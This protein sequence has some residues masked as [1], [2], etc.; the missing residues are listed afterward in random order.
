MVWPWRKYF[1]KK[2][3]EEEEEEGGKIDRLER[4]LLWEL[5]RYG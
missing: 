5:L 3:E 2:K 1:E 4:C